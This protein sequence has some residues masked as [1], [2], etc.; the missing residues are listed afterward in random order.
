MQAHTHR[1]TRSTS[2]LILIKWIFHAI[3]SATVFSLLTFL[4]QLAFFILYF[5]MCCC[6]SCD[7]RK[8]WIGAASHLYFLTYVLACQLCKSLSLLNSLEKH[9][10]LIKICLFS[11]VPFTLPLCRGCCLSHRIKGCPT[12]SLCCCGVETLTETTFLLGL[13]LLLLINVSVIN[14]L[15]HKASPHPPDQPDSSIQAPKQHSVSK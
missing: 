15:W 3:L 12:F 1:R 4:H 14:L 8:W 13:R 5:R 10:L 6:I 9:L 2:N 11:C 7:F